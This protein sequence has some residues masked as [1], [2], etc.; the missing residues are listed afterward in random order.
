MGEPEDYIGKKKEREEEKR[1]NHMD[2]DPI[3]EKRCAAEEEIASAV[4]RKVPSVLAEGAQDVRVRRGLALKNLFHIFGLRDEVASKESPEK[5]AEVPAPG[6][7][8][9]IIHS[10]E[11]T[12]LREA[13]EE[14]EREGRAT[15]T[16]SGES[17]ADRV[18]GE[19]FRREACL[20]CAPAGLEKALLVVA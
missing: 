1:E 15:D 3:P 20:D 13:L 18:G 6:D 10:P 2:G 17:H 4:W 8:R 14:S 12:P 16:S 9:E 7:R 19:H 5:G 11:K